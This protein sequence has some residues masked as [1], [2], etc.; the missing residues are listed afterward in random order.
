MHASTLMHTLALSIKKFP[1]CLF[2]PSLATF[3]LTTIWPP[4]RLPVGQHD[5][6]KNSKANLIKIETHESYIYIG[7]HLCRRCSCL[8]ARHHSNPRISARSTSTPLAPV[9]PGSSCAVK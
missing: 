8:R 2:L 7:P 4:T 6:K 5:Q 3:F 1:F 9:C